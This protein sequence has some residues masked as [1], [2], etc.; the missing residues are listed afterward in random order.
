MT[1]KHTNR[2]SQ[3][4]SPYLLQHQHNP[5][6][7]YPWGAEALQKAKTEE[8][9]IILSIGYSACHW[10]HVMEHESFEE[11]AVAEV[12]NRG[13]VCIKLDREERPDID[14]IYMDAVQA[15][16]IQGGWP[17][18]VFLTPDQKPFYGG[19][20]F[21]RE[22]WVQLLQNVEKAWRENRQALEESSEKF[23]DTLSYSDVERF[24]L[25]QHELQITK[26]KLEHLFSGFAK[27]FDKDRGGLSPAPKFPMPSHW[28][29]LLRYWAAVGDSSALQ[30]A[31]LTLREMAWGGIYDQV[32]GGFARYSVDAEWFVPHF[33]KMLYDNGQL[34][35]LYAS[36]YTATKDELFKDVVYQTIAWAERE[37]LS[38]Q[39][40]FYAALDA[41]SEGEEGKFYVWTIA[42]LEEVLGKEEAELVA[43]YYNASEEGNWEG[44]NI[45]FRRESPG[46]FAR[47]YELDPDDLEQLLAEARQLLLD[48][49]SRRI[50]PGLDDKILAAWNGLMLTGLCEAYASF[51]EPRFL[52]L[53]QQNATFIEKNLLQGSKLRRNHKAGAAPSPAFLDDYAFVI[54]GFLRLYGVSFEEHWL[55]LAE[56]LTDFCLQDFWDANESLFFYTGKS[57]ETLIARKKELFDNVIPSSN[58]QMAYNLYQLGL[59]LEKDEYSKIAAGMVSAVERLLLTEPQYLTHWLG[60]YLQMAYPTAEVAI[61]GPTCREKA[62]ELYQHYLPNKVVAATAH[63]SKLPLL[64]YRQHKEDETQIYV[65]YNRACQK[66]VTEVAEAVQQIREVVKVE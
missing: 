36:A 9:P 38:P 12:M 4:S 24:G 30:Q 55:Q 51:G 23:T 25:E 11:E 17:L 28:Q 15:M 62:L 43:D 34:I 46:D 22:H 37:M 41:D 5:V 7:W 10:C 66:P 33:E 27:K 64:Q 1:A 35:S 6:D 57:S 39:G 19:T 3:S 63:E 44:A 53:A 54:G 13:F 61:A 45:L 8:K 31:L 52:T 20:Y 50:R 40:G 32:G 48:A 16:G 14:Q 60:L 59:L 47:K 56:Q 49:R 21:P 29:F 18:N 26:L 65:C 42:E 58:S 2:L